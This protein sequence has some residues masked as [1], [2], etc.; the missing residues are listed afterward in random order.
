MIVFYDRCAP[1]RAWWIRDGTSGLSQMISAYRSF[2]RVARLIRTLIDWV[3]LT[4]DR[5]SMSDLLRYL[6]GFTT[7]GVRERPMLRYR[8]KY[9]H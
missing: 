3:L 8:L 1:V 4:T 5:L 2:V 7:G 6:E 9:L